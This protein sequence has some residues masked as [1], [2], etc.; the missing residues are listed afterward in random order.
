MQDKIVFLSRNLSKMT[1][2]KNRTF[3]LSHFSHRLWLCSVWSWM[4]WHV[5]LNDIINHFFECLRI[6]L[7]FCAFG[8]APPKTHLYD[9]LRAKNTVLDFIEKNTKDANSIWARSKHIFV[10]FS[11]LVVLECFKPPFQSNILFTSIM[12]MRILSRHPHF[13][14]VFL[15]KMLYYYS[16]C[17]LVLTR[18]FLLCGR[19]KEC[20]GVKSKTDV[21]NTFQTMF[22]APPKTRFVPTLRVPSTFAFGRVF[23]QQVCLV[24][25]CMTNINH[26]MASPMGEGGGGWGVAV[27]KIREIC[28]PHR[29]FSTRNIQLKVDRS[30]EK[31]QK[32][33]SVGP[34]LF[35]Q[36]C[37]ATTNFTPIL[38]CLPTAHGL[39]P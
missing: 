20:P 23:Y 7:S 2:K 11:G 8:F 18:F 25:G 33:Y 35:S 28:I 31:F 37:I 4:P 22:R 30:A 13:S 34:S 14:L 21:W 10:N 39:R 19:E 3:Y 36:E 1:R 29:L 24:G 15:T 38:V 27:G 32:K 26:N 12:K 6:F 9:S 16:H 17:D 5:E